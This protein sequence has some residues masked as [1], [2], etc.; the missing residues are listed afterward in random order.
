LLPGMELMGC[1]NLAVP[2]EVMHHVVRVESSYNP[3]A[4]GVVGGRLVRQP[5]NLPEALATV[6]MLEGRGF[7]FSIGLAQ[8]NRYNLGKYGLDSYEKAFEPCANLTAGSKI[9]AECYQRAK[10]D[11]GKSFSCYYSGNFATGFRHGYVQKIYA[12][13]R[14]GREVET[15]P[16][17]PAIEVFARPSRRTVPVSRHPIYTGVAPTEPM[18]QLV[19]TKIQPA[20]AVALPSRVQRVP[21]RVATVEPTDTMPSLVATTSALP[22]VAQATPMLASLPVEPTA[23]AVLI[24]DTNSTARAV[25]TQPVTA[26]EPSIV[27][28]RTAAGD[29]AFVVS[30]PDQDEAFVF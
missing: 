14:Q 8:V 21:S 4:I 16:A 10:G 7:N 2:S 6:R 1:Q 12:S 3:Y 19:A 29:K 18:N 22:T 26:I 9:L 5:K 27:K 11:W 28:R 13:L 17:S 30:D 25:V 15:T 23:Q 24:S 20:A